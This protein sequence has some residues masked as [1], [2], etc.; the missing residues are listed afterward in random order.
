MIRGAPSFFS[1]F[2]LSLWLTIFF[3][4]AVPAILFPL[5]GLVVLAV[6]IPILCVENPRWKQAAVLLGFFALGL[7]L[8]ALRTP[9]STRWE[10]YPLLLPGPTA[11]TAVPLQQ[12][13]EFR[14]ALI[15]DSTAVAGFTGTLTRY[16]IRLEQV[17]SADGQR[18]GSAAGTVLVWI[19]GGPML[20][21]GQQVTVYAGLELYRQA[22]RFAYTAWA[23]SGQLREGVFARR[24]DLLRARIFAVLQSRM[25]RLDPPVASLLQALVLGRREELD[26]C[27]YE[28]F[29]TSGSLHLLALSGLHLGIFYLLMN[30]ALRFLRDRRARRLVAGGLLLGYVFLVG[31]RPS[32]ERAAVMLLV[33]AFGHALDRDIQP[34][35]LLGA[36]AAMLLLAHP[37]YTFDLSFQLSFLSLGA[38]LLLSPYLYRIWQS[39]LPAFLG[40]PLGVSLS[41]QVGAAPL[42]LYHFGAIYPVGVVAALVLIP[43]VAVFLGGGVVFVALTFL[44]GGVSRL[45]ADG[46]FLVYRSIAFSLDLFSRIPGLY[47]S[48]RSVYWLLLGILPVPMTIEAWMRRRI[49]AC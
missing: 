1:L 42:V 16:P 24:I 48:W 22:G 46:L 25:Q 23:E 17:V 43:L 7:V 11:H 8:G 35:N 45:L 32:L 9:E 19:R 13:G 5:V 49:P 29:R 3:T 39:Y 15:A 34:L 30:L 20:F 41:A 18:S 26:S 44:P 6:S 38:I 10:R 37:H 40:W 36:A 33:A 31:W 27:L 47:L 4:G 14:G 2:A 21:R 12:V 28:K